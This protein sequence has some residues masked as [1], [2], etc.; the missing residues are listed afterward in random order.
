MVVHEWQQTAEQVRL[1]K[2]VMQPTPDDKLVASV[3]AL[4]LNFGFVRREDVVRWAD[5]RI[6]ECE[7]APGWLIDVSLSQHRQLT[8]LIGE[9]REIGSGVNSTA[10]CEAAFGLL[11]DLKGLTFDVA[12]AVGKRL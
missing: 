4:G 7:V 10:M 2:R 12:E 8:D 3:F 11:P 5:Q 1:L 9:L 6:V